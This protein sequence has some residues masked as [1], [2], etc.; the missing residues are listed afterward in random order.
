MRKHKCEQFRQEVVEYV[1]I[2]PDQ[3]VTNTAKLIGA[4]LMADQQRLRSLERKY[5]LLR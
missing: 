3:S 1:L 2:H 4:A 5:A